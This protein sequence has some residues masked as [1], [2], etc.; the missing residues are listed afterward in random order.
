MASDKHVMNDKASA[1]EW[2]NKFQRLPDDAKTILFNEVTAEPN[3]SNWAFNL[4]M[5]GFEPQEYEF[6]TAYCLKVTSNRKQSLQEQILREAQKQS[7][8][9]IS[10]SMIQQATTDKSKKEKQQITLHKLFGQKEAAIRA[11]PHMKKKIPSTPLKRELGDK[12]YRITKGH[13]SKS[14]KKVAREMKEDFSPPELEYI[15]DNDLIDEHKLRKDILF[16]ISKFESIGA[17]IDEFMNKN[18]NS[19]DKVLEDINS[20]LNAQSKLKKQKVSD[21]IAKHCLRVVKAISYCDNYILQGLDD[22]AKIIEFSL[23]HVVCS[24]C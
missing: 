19:Q 14:S 18:T 1:S 20:K 15:K 6:V 17:D 16:N 11:N 13:T 3:N 5:F 24:V 7:E 9:H 23:K 8:K 4:K 21:T 22:R 12:L 10:Q 2:L